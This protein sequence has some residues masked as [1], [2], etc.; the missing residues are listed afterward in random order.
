MAKQFFCH[1][2]ASKLAFKYET[3]SVVLLPQLWLLHEGGGDVLPGGTH[4]QGFERLKAGTL[5]P[6]QPEYTV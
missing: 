1:I 4:S 2:P 5:L 6:K 3:V